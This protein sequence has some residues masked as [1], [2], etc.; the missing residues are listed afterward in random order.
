MEKVLTSALVALLMTA[1]AMA[2]SL[3][4]IKEDVLA[5]YSKEDFSEMMSMLTIHD[6]HAVKQMVDQGK[7]VGLRRGSEVYLQSI[8]VIAG[9]AEVRP[10]GSTVT[11][12]I[13][14]DVV[15]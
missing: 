9:I 3:H 11:V 12:W 15:D 14:S 6:T 2:L 10:K 1:T 8:D 7:V 13:S 5:A 4:R